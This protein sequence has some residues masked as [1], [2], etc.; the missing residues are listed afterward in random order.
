[1]PKRTKVKTDFTKNVS[2]AR[3]N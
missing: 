3:K 2:V 1:V